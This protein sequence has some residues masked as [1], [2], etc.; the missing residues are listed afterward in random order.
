MEKLFTI[1]FRITCNSNEVVYFNGRKRISAEKRAY[2][3]AR[4]HTD[5]KAD[6]Q[7][8]IMRL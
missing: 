7:S 2:A 3:H 8:K 1:I 6:T 4:M 5:T